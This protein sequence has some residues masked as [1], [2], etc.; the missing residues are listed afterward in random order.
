[1][2]VATKRA[3]GN[4]TKQSH[5]R[6]LHT[7][8]AKIYSIRR[9]PPEKI[10]GNFIDH[11]QHKSD[12]AR[13]EA[14]LLFGGFYADTDTLSLRNLD[15][16]L[17]YS[18]TMGE[19]RPWDLHNAAIFAEAHAAHMYMWYR[20]YTTFSASE[21]NE[22]SISGNMELAQRCPE[23]VH[24]EST[25]MVTPNYDNLHMF[26]DENMT[27]SASFTVHLY[28]RHMEYDH[29]AN[30]SSISSSRGLVAR[31]MRNVYYGQCEV[32]G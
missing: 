23:F 20:S 26:D 32:C 1:M 10:Y 13:I 29:L 28:W 3:A 15:P 9:D 22:H 14:L 8:Q 2:T 11:V 17:N 31:L 5:V 7:F 16:L 12:V 19:E 24:I 6:V 18:V 21:W 4:G 30:P 25:S 27:I